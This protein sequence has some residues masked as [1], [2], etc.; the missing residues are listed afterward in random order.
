MLAT[1][2][3]SLLP[4]I[5]PFVMK[6]AT[7]GIILVAGKVSGLWDLAIA[8]TKNLKLQQAERQL[9]SLSGPALTTA[10]TT[11]GADLLAKKSMAEIA[12]D[13]A[14]ALKG[15]VPADTLS[16]LISTLAGAGVDEVQWLIGHF[17]Q[18]VS[19]QM[20]FSQRAD[21]ST[22][23]GKVLSAPDGFSANHT[24]AEIRNEIAAKGV[25]VPAL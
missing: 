1:I 25:S 11:I 17:S 3:S 16:T 19:Y 6:A 8:H 5:A 20:P 18:Q 10:L 4:L 9:Q 13:A 7:A 2:L 21:F 23:V 22:P 24:A 12:A 14:T 15:M